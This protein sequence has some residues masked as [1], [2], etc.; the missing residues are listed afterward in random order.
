MGKLTSVSNKHV[1]KCELEKIS[2]NSDKMAYFAYLENGKR[3]RLKRTTSILNILGKDVL[4]KW[5]ADMAGSYM[6]KWLEPDRKYSQAQ[7]NYMADQA[8]Q[9]HWNYKNET[10]ELGTEAHYWIERFLRSGEWPD[11]EM[12]HPAVVNSLHLFSQFWSENDFEV[13]E[14]EYRCFDL[15]LGYG[16]TCDLIVRCRRTNRILLIDWKTGSG[17]W[18]TYL[19]QVAAYFGA[20]YKTSPYKPDGA[21]IV[22]IGREDAQVQL[23]E[24]PDEELAQGYIVFRHIA[25][26]QPMVSKLDG[27]YY[28]MTKKWKS[29][30]ALTTQTLAEREAHQKNVSA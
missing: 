11:N 23:H 7:I 30:R 3:I 14:I 25:K 8:A 21:I 12:L 19:F 28:R 6:K 18:A 9:A 2:L 1:I 17:I 4:I 15:E 29:A 22:R 27:R 20:L 16:G 5:A 13:L 24:I 10:G 26:I